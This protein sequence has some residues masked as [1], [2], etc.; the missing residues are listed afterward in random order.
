[1]N[2]VINLKPIY[3][4]LSRDNWCQKWDWIDYI[5]R[6]E[7]ALKRYIVILESGT[8]YEAND[9]TPASQSERIPQG[10]DS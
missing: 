6:L 7:I 5:T 4:H 8:T 3:S 9:G 1:M 2:Q 10:Y